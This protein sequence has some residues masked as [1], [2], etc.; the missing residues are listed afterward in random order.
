MRE[1]KEL[2]SGRILV[3][4]NN[5]SLNEKRNMNGTHSVAVESVSSQALIKASIR[6]N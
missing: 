4:Q 2:F 1:M 5:P 3:T 6:V